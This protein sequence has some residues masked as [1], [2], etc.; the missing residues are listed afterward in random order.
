MS[1][2]VTGS[3]GI[4]SVQTPFGKVEGVL[5]GSASYFAYT[6]SFFSPVRLVGA[7]GPDLSRGVSRQV[8]PLTR[9]PPA[10]MLCVA[11]HH[12]TVVN[13]PAPLHLQS[14]AAAF[15]IIAPCGDAYR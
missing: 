11:P 13:I 5:G 1:L 6:A 8:G 10:V 14:R 3:I 4:D 7:V 9:T 12:R 2:L 15:G